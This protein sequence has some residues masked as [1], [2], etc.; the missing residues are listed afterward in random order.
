MDNNQNFDYKIFDSLIDSNI[1][2][3]IYRF[4]GQ[5][6]INLILQNTPDPERLHDFSGLDGKSGFVIAPFR[7]TSET[8]I[9]IIRPDVL[10]KGEKTIFKY[11]ADFVVESPVSQTNI[12]SQSHLDSLEKYKS[13]FEIFHSA[14]DEEKFQKLVL[15]RT[16]DYKKESD[17]S[18]GESFRRACSKYPYN[19][20][21]LCYTPCTGTWMG[22]S[23]E[24]LVSEENGTSKTVALAGT[25]DLNTEKWDDKNRHEQQIVVDYMR[26]QLSGAGYK[27]KESDPFTVQSGNINHLKTEFS[28]NLTD[29]NKIGDLLEL[30]HPSPAVCGFPK[31][32]AF[33][34]IGKQEGYDRRYY[35]GFVGPLNIQNNSGL[36]VNLRCMQIGD[37]ILRLYAGGGLLSSSDMLSEW[38]ETENKLQTILAVI[39]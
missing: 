7:I 11:F 15:S 6:D 23:P 37:D 34:F 39:N 4:P 1:R 35:S 21:F 16:A 5:K 10:L 25:K 32:D 33:D 8:P 20:I 13:K 38:K 12:Q 29:R 28:F 18:A 2:F 19:F 14:I 27:F 30:L 26:Q 3:S 36:Y 17:F 31:E 24:L 9:E 22:I